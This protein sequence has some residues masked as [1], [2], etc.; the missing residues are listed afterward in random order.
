V[1][2]GSRLWIVVGKETAKKLKKE[3][4]FVL[5]GYFD[6]S[7]LNLHRFPFDASIYLFLYDPRS[8][9]EKGMDIQID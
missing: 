6:G 5:K 4:P 2:D 8:P 9:N 3:S 7:F 1:A